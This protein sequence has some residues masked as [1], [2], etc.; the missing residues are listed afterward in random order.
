MRRGSWPISVVRLASSAVNSPDASLAV[1]RFEPTATMPPSTA[2]TAAATT[3][4]LSWIAP[5]L[6][7]SAEWGHKS[8]GQSRTEFV[9]I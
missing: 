8:N 1:L 4:G 9:H 6:V 7:E 5:I 2:A 3:D